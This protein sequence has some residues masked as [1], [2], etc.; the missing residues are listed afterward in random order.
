MDEVTFAEGRMVEG[1]G[2][3]RLTPLL[4]M[5]GHTRLNVLIATPIPVEYKVRILKFRSNGVSEAMNSV[6]TFDSVYT[7]SRQFTVDVNSKFVKIEI[8]LLSTMNRQMAI[9]AYAESADPTI[10]DSGSLVAT[11]DKKTT[12]VIGRDY[13]MLMSEVNLANGLMVNANGGTRTTPLLDMAGYNRID[14]TILT[15]APSRYKVYVEEY[16]SNG[17]SEALTNTTEYGP[18]IDSLRFK[19]DVNSKFVKIKIESL[20]EENRRMAIYA[21]AEHAEPNVDESGNLVTTLDKKSINAI[22][23]QINSLQLQ[24]SSH[25]DFK[26]PKLKNVKIIDTK[27]RSVYTFKDGL[28]YGSKG[29]TIYTSADGESWE[30]LKTIPTVEGNG[31][32]KLIISDTNRF[33]VCM[34]NGEIW[35]SD[36]SGNFGTTRNYKTGNFTYAYGSTQYANVIGLTTYEPSGL[37]ESKKH[38]AW[39]STD[40][41]AT[42]KK[43]FDKNTIV[44]LQP[45]NDGRVH[46]HDIEYDPYS[47]VIYI[48]NGD[49]GNK[50]LNYST[51]MGNTWKMVDETKQNGNTTQLLAT[52]KGIA[53][54]GDT[55]GGGIEYIN[56][57]RSQFI[58][59]DIKESDIDPEYWKFND[60]LEDGYV[61]SR[62][63]AYRKFVNR[64]DGVYLIPYKP[65]YL[66]EGDF[67][68]TYIAYSPDGIN[69]SILWRGYES[70]HLLGLDDIVY[71]NGKLVG[72]YNFKEGETDS[73]RKLFIADM[74]I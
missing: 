74:E 9:F 32:Q 64:E 11:L 66:K 38:E 12:D 6:I 62:Y 26:V 29:P 55:Y 52:E 16:R 27:I 65:E 51:D 5:G 46:L 14:L 22:G 23:N 45:N 57:D 17:T 73:E 44:E 35:I 13:K 21:Y 33:V 3:K 8:E 20:F 49:F 2:G 60:G 37:E 42:F 63:I 15:V 41:G 58:F 40:N 68:T 28:F 24:T 71:G 31:I 56:I 43:I 4:D 1:S 67:K 50:A 36:E 59:P 10:D 53:L 34:G 19:V 69:W 25:Q 70:G 18:F 30:Q 47:G 54:C 39:L 48:W 7:N 72:S 61:G